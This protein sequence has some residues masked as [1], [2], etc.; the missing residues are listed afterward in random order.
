MSAEADVGDWVRRLVQ[1]AVED[2]LHAWRRSGELLRRLASGTLDAQALRDE[3]VRFS[4]EES[5]RYARAAAAIALSSS[6]ALLELERARTD[7]FYDALLGVRGPA[8]DEPAAR[9]AE[10]AA[11]PPDLVLAGV[12]GSEASGAFTLDNA[13]A[14]PVSVTFAVSDFVPAGG[15]PRFRPPPVVEPESLTLP[16]GGSQRVT[17]RVPLLADVFAVGRS[18]ATLRV[19]GRDDLDVVLAVDVAAAPVLATAPEDAEP[20]RTDA[21]AADA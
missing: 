15:G 9:A 2:Q 12:L 7:A 5:A 19:R 18:T 13:E 3:L 8:A 1:R 10:D 6:D 16:P 4:Q 17:L 14:E 21:D 20:S 11:V